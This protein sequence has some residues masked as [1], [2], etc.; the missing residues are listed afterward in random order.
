MTSAVAKALLFHPQLAIASILTAAKATDYIGS[1]TLQPFRY[2]N[3]PTLQ[4]SEHSKLRKLKT[5]NFPTTLPQRSTPGR[6]S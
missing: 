3:T 2:S 5:Q 1:D 6:P 4:Y